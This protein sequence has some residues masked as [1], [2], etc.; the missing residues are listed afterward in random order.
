MFKIILKGFK[1][2]FLSL[3][4]IVFIF[5]LYLVLFVKINPPKIQDES[6]IQQKRVMV[7][8]DYYKVGNNYLRKNEYGIWEMYVEGK[9][10]ERGAV[11]GILGK[12]LL[13]YQEDVFISEIKKIIPSDFY[14][15]FLKYLVAWFN[16]DMDEYV[17]KEY[18]EEIYGES[19]SAPDK[20]DF[21]GPKYQRMLNYHA[22][23]DIGHALQSRNFVVGCTSF[24]GWNNKTADSSLILARNF[25]FYVGDD[26][27]R[28]KI[29]LLCH[30][31]S[32]INFMSVTW[33]GMIGA[34]SGMNDAGLAVTIN[35]GTAE[36]PTK[37]ATPI[38]ILVREI[39]QYAHNI[40]E[41]V[42]IAS[43][44]K[45]FVS[46]SIM[47]A[48]AS[49]KKTVIIE[50]SPTK[51]DVF[52]SKD[53]LLIC[54]N[55]FQSSSFSRDPENMKNISESTSES[56]YQRVKSLVSATPA[57]SVNSAAAIL[58]DRKG[59]FE[60]NIGEGNEQAINQLIAHHS[61]IFKPE[62][63]T[64]WI[65]TNPW[66]LGEF[67][68]YNL[69]SAFSRAQHLLESSEIY[70]KTMNIPADTFLNSR[71][72]Y[73][74][75]EFRIIKKYVQFAAKN[76]S[77]EASEAQILSLV[78]TNPSYYYSYALAGEYY[79]AHDNKRE[80]KKYFIIALLK[81][82]SCLNEKIRIERQIKECE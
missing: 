16:R 4:A 11:I 8:K 60:K 1:Y 64:A 47:V 14:L 79:F 49:D 67:V 65:S 30:P 63:K 45:T 33:P 78:H 37:S 22:A 75:L 54:S 43:A 68:C 10:F 80:A 69:D 24:A 9:P 23:H 62:R 40:D 5:T 74:F 50:K 55:H 58:R 61:V 41:A 34:V 42:K 27:A 73:D 15:R 57:L 28:N 48:S 46:E 72:Y 81:E 53:N 71:E 59:P 20:Y 31:A 76:K 35:A 39:L 52:E 25:D 77:H 38:S 66:Q 6:A 26:F 19:L 12:E 17:P 51:Q 29:I 21:V 18:L 32:G 13:E 70:D 44:R 36:A 82:P 3:I 56:R 7:S 2:F